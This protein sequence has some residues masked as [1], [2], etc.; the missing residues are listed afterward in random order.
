MGLTNRLL[1]LTSA[2]VNAFLDSAEDPE[3]AVLRLNSELA[4]NLK[5]AGRAEAK[6]RSALKNEQSR[7]DEIRGRIDRLKHGALLAIQHND[8]ELAREA[9]AEQ[10]KAEEQLKQRTASLKRS[11]EALA[12]ARAARLQVKQRLEELNQHYVDILA[13]YRNIQS[14]TPKS[15]SAQQGASDILAEVA[16]IDTSIDE[17]IAPPEP[18]APELTLEERLR[19]LEVQLEINRRIEYIRRKQGTKTK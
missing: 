8:E 10:I 3:T 11:E 15:S 7:L 4:E 13:R 9:I 5:L 18:D 1:Q 2:R 16:R 12:N 14:G 19:K 6:A 17:D